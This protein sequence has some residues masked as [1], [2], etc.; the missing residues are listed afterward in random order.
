M[1]HPPFPTPAN[2]VRYIRYIINATSPT[3]RIILRS[4]RSLRD[5][6]LLQEHASLKEEYASLKWSLSAS[7]NDG[8]EYG[9][10]KNPVIRKILLAAGWTEVEVDEKEA[11]DRR[12]PGEM[13]R[14][15]AY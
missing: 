13:E 9:Q 7:T 5:I 10:G 1:S 6:L 14:E 2:N 12:A 4:H 3:G 8:V 15:E 11:L